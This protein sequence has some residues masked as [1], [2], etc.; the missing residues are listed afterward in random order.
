MKKYVWKYWFAGVRLPKTLPKGCEQYNGC[1]KKWYLE[2]NKPNL[3]SN[4][5]RRWKVEVKG[6]CQ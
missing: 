3:W 4:L 6:R 2:T 1:N 5:P